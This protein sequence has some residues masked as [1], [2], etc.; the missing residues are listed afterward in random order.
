MSDRLTAFLTTRTV[1]EWGERGAAVELYGGGGR[2][3]QRQSV[4][5]HDRPQG[6]QVTL[7]SAACAH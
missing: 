3:V 7:L 6:V 5:A 2:H 4:G 1:T